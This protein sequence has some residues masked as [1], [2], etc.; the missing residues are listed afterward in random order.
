MRKVA[1]KTSVPSSR[2]LKIFYYRDIRGEWRWHMKAPNGQVIADS[3]EGYS[4]KGNVQ[5]AAAVMVAQVRNSVS[6]QESEVR[7][8][9]P[10]N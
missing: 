7:L 3:G 2:A 5:R 4:S 9:T 1:A 6:I 8:D 10:E